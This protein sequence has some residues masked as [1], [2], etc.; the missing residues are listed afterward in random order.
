MNIN[1]LTNDYKNMPAKQVANKHGVHINTVYRLSK[2]TKKNNRRWTIK[3]VEL[4]VRLYEKG[5]TY[6]QIASNMSR[7]VASV[8]EKLKK[9]NNGT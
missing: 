8:Y 7:T 2:H 1:Q 9:V 5:F 6:K 4:L 3:D